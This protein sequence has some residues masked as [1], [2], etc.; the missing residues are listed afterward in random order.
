MIFEKEETDTS[1]SILVNFRLKNRNEVKNTFTQTH[2]VFW[3]VLVPDLQRWLGSQD[4]KLQTRFDHSII[5]NV[6]FIF[7][8]HLKI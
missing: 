6:D 7:K 8:V 2:Y 5:D 4:P 3:L 1:D